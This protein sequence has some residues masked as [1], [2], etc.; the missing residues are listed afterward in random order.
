[1]SDINLDR[2]EKQN[3]DVHRDGVYL[4]GRLV[5]GIVTLNVLAVDGVPGC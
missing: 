1:M 5:D 2:I 4:D 3:S